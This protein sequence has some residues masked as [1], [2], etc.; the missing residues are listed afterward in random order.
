MRYFDASALDP[1]RF[2]VWEGGIR[3]EPNS[4]ESLRYVRHTI[5]TMSNELSEELLGTFP[6]PRI[7][8]IRH[9]LIMA[10]APFQG[11]GHVLC[12]DL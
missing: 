5:P 6:G 4:H 10:E 8:R 11:L 1:H 7:P 9:Y 2:D 12:L 3:P